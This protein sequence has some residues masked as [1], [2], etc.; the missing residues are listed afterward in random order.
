MTS[1]IPLGLFYQN[2]DAAIYNELRMNKSF[3]TEE[4]MANLE[5]EFDRF[6]I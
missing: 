3:T 4:K 2:K 1:H 5:K 6:A